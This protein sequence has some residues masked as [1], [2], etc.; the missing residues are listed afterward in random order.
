MIL[1][2]CQILLI[3]VDGLFE[4][5]GQ[6]SVWAWIPIMSY[7]VLKRKRGCDLLQIRPIH[8]YPPWCFVIVAP[9][10]W[11]LMFSWGCQVLFICIHELLV[12]LQET[13]TRTSMQI[14]LLAVLMKEAGTVQIK[15]I[16]AY[17]PWD[18]VVIAPSP[19]WL[20]HPQGCQTFF[21]YMYEFFDAWGQLSIWVSMQTILS[22]VLKWESVVLKSDQFIPTHHEVL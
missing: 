22:T 12:A 1:H 15:P 16:H 11:Q 17:S 19:W 4:V 21:M 13:F 10:R 5:C 7:T 3:Y 20:M 9:W 8:A 2:G 14:I 6:L 18:L